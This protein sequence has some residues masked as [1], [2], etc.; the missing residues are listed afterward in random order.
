MMS[1]GVSLV[2]ADMLFASSLAADPANANYDFGARRILPLY[3][4]I[5]ERADLR[6]LL[7]KM[8]RFVLRGSVKD[9][10]V[11]SDAWRAFDA[12]YTKFFVADFQWTRMNW[13]NLVA[14]SAMVRGWIHL[15]GPEAF[16]AQEVWFLSRVVEE[17]GRGQSIDELCDRLFEIVWQMRIEPALGFE[18]PF[19]AIA[20]RSAGFRR[21][22]T[23]QVAFFARYAPIVA[24]PPLASELA[25][26]IRDLRPFEDGEIAEIRTRFGDYVRAL[27]KEGIVSDD[28]AEIFPDLFP[29]FDP[30]FLRDY[31]VAKQEYATVAEASAR[32]FEEA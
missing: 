6:A 5:G 4:A 28:D 7:Q 11:E 21:W 20:A 26:R 30:F 27:A 15:V 9:L 22:L 18:K 31:D 17:V 2:L 19:D 8:T 24:P 10:P 25:A 13:Q 29:L 16:D 3:R 32:A 12:K 14:R 1:E 23:G